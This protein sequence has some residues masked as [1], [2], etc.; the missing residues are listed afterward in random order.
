MNKI[1]EES[2]GE[3]GEKLF[4]DLI[5]GQ[6]S[7]EILHHVFLHNI[8]NL[9]WKLTD[10]QVNQEESEAITGIIQADDNNLMKLIMESIFLSLKI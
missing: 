6:S 9:E 10:M 8:M 2:S 5:S 7:K 1:F 4:N 3:A